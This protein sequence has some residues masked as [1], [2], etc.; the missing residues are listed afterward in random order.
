VGDGVCWT[1]AAAEL[2]KGVK[3]GCPAEHLGIKRQRGA[4]RA[5]E[6]DVGC[7]PGHRARSYRGRFQRTRDLRAR[8]LPRR[9]GDRER[10][11]L[12]GALDGRQSRSLSGALRVAGYLGGMPELQ[13]LSS[14][15]LDAVLKFE[16]ENRAYFAR[17]LTDRGDEFYTDLAE[18]HQALL[19]EQDAGV[20]V[21]FVLVDSK[22]S[23]VGRF[24]LYDLDDG[25]AR[26]GYR[27]SERA[28]GRGAATQAVMELCS[29]ARHEYDLRTLT[30]ETSVANFASQRVLEKAG[31]T[32]TG[33]CVVA[34]KPGRR[35]RIEL[36]DVSV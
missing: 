17:S 8:F 12:S 27:V 23:I 3:L 5:G 9:S 36:A 33:S 22:G 10:Q 29:R 11:P 25:A 24:N 14:A 6:V 19:D 16:H 26:V 31:F 21:F 35:F 32:P 28:A 34:G 20:C 15:H 4:S 2:S 18:H 7:Q 13:R 30:A 1:V